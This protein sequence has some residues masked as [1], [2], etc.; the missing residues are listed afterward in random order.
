[1]G[2]LPDTGTTG[3]LSVTSASDAWL[4]LVR[5]DVLWK[6]TDGGHAWTAAAPAK[7]EEQFPQ[8]LSLAQQSVFVKT[9][10]ALWEHS[11][12]GWKLVA[13]RPSR[14]Q[15]SRGK[16]RLATRPVGFAA[17]AAGS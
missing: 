11:V 4:I 6:T 7:V 5:N 2:A 14:G 1:M 8:E 9:Q 17:V 16:P 3:Y 13:G 10:N 12:K 15:R